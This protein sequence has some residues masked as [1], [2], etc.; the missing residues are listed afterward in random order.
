MALSNDGKT[1]VRN[2]AVDRLP[3]TMISDASRSEIR[4]D[5]PGYAD[6]VD[7]EWLFSNFDIWR[8]DFSE[9]LPETENPLYRTAILEEKFR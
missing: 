4:T 5:D 2:A 6:G 3:E 1:A 7:L 9:R 8:L